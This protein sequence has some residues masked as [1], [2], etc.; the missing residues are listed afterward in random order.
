MRKKASHSYHS[1]ATA[2][3]SRIFVAPSPLVPRNLLIHV[4]ANEDVSQ[5][6]EM[7]ISPVNS[8]LTT[9]KLHRH[10]LIRL[11][12]TNPFCLGGILSI[13]SNPTL[14]ATLS[15]LNYLLRALIYSPC[16]AI[17]NSATLS[18]VLLNSQICDA[19]A[20]LS[21]NKNT[22]QKVVKRWKFSV[23]NEKYNFRTYLY[24]Y[25]W[26]N[27]AVPETDEHNKMKT[28]NIELNSSNVQHNRRDL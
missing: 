22:W 25:T 17:G 16:L 2:V 23:N 19:L 10:K 1:T 7:I 18:H 9:V 14:H 12:R 27:V 21:E 13:H 5:L 26:K 8:W 4:A 3:F 15:A 6:P 11:V 28:S 20:K 24:F